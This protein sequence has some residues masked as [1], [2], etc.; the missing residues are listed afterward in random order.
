MDEEERRLE[1]DRQSHEK[2]M[3]EREI[4][5]QRKFQEMEDQ[6]RG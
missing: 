2:M 3:L 6:R 1:E 4:Y 5:Y